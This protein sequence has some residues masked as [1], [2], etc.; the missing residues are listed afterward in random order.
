M[1]MD[2]APKAPDIMTAEDIL[3]KMRAGIKETYE[4]RM[5]EMRIPVRV[6][7]I[8]EVNDI[9]REALKL[10]MVSNG[11]E[12]DKNVQIQRMTLKLATTL[13]PGT[14]PLLSDKLLKMLSVDEIN[15]L[16]EEFVNVMDRVNPT[17][18]TISPE[19]FKELVDALKK[20]L[21]SPKDLSTRQLRA[22]CSAYVDLIQRQEIVS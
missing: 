5:R 8:D 10:T 17:L 19:Q 20:T 4:I 9:R 11:D 16:Y 21:V 15:Y 12:T 1:T 2:R 7:T 13:K 6:L 14:G 3:A 18:E 22:I